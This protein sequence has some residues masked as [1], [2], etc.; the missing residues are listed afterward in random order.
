[1]GSTTLEGYETSPLGDG[2]RSTLIVAT[3]ARD[4]VLAGGF[5]E[6]Q[7]VLETRS[8]ELW[9]SGG[10]IPHPV[11]RVDGELWILKS[12]RRGG[13]LAH[14]NRDLYLGGERFFRELRVCV[15]ALRAGVPTVPLLALIIRRNTFGLTRAW[16]ISP[17]VEN[18]ATLA[19]LLGAP[20]GAAAADSDGSGPPEDAAA[21]Y[22]AFRRAGEAVRRMH[23]CGIDHRDLNL[24]N[25]L[26]D[27]AGGRVLVLD[28]DRARLLNGP[29]AEAFR[30]LLRLFRSGLKLR[31]DS[32]RLGA[33]L[34]AFLR[35]YFSTD[36]D[37]L[38]RLRRFYRKRRF[39]EI[40]L[41]RLF[42]D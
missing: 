29:G 6:P 14:W 16:S 35:G 38:R 5:S 36:R 23:G 30:N 4:R 31:P 11:F 40:S 32:R 33:A 20:E 39:T 42:W 12:Y 3:E 19:T 22:T 17:F 41:H 24:N 21:F 34:R 28:W 2:A 25:L 18:A 10:R 9:T 15:H 8:V 13:W 1:M 27:A 26:F 37:G 7:R